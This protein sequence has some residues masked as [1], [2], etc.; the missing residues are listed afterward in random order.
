MRKEYGL[1]ARINQSVCIPH[2]L[3]IAGPL[4][5]GQVAQ[6]DPAVLQQS[7]SIALH[8]REAGDSLD[9]CAR[10]GRALHA[11]AARECLDM[12]RSL[13]RS[14]QRQDSSRRPGWEVVWPARERSHC[15]RP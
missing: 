3:C 6:E 5:A 1:W 12:L 15:G 13:F 9:F 7:S 2:F 14:P 4:G 10:Y 8:H 11:Q